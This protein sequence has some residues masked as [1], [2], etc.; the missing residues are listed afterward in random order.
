MTGRKGYMEF[1]KIIGCDVLKIALQFKNDHDRRNFTKTVCL[2]WFDDFGVDNKDVR[3]VNCNT[4]HDDE[5]TDTKTLDINNSTSDVDTNR[6]KVLSDALTI[7]E[8]QLQNHSNSLRYPKIL[9]ENIDSQYSGDYQ[10]ILRLAVWRKYVK[11]LLTLTMHGKLDQSFFGH[12]VFENTIFFSRTTVW[13]P[14]DSRKKKRKYLWMRSQETAAEWCHRVRSDRGVSFEVLPNQV[15]NII[16]KKYWSKGV[17]TSC[18]LC[19]FPFHE[20]NFNYFDFD[21]IDPT[22]KICSL[23]DIYNL[24]RRGITV[25]DRVIIRELD[26]CRPL[27]KDCH[28]N[29]TKKQHI[30]DAFRK[31]CYL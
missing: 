1:I 31:T 2:L 24:L 9:S 11:E 30:N 14:P 15:K 20:D 3:V 25:D 8:D 6:S 7:C 27:C 22:K 21:H 13:K 4:S 16:R 23:C 19:K 26:Q 18:E 29:H 17:D 5:D 28:L 12:C 10:T